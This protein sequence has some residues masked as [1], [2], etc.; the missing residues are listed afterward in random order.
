[1]VALVGPSGAGK[2]TLA[3]LVPRLYDVTAGA[4]RIDGND[5]RDLTQTSLRAAIGVVAQDPH[6]FHESVGANLR[7]ARPDGHAR[8]SWR[9]PAGRPQIHDVIA[10]LP[11]GYDTIVGERG[12]PAVGRREAAPGHRPHAA[13]GPVHRDPRRGHQP[14]RPEN[15]ALVQEALDEALAGPHLDRDRP[16]PVDHPPGRPDLVVDD[17]RI[18]EQGTH[19]ALVE[20]GGLYADLYQTLG[21]GLARRPS[22]LRASREGQIWVW[23]M[24]K[25]LHPPHPR[26]L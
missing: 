12:L 8:P 25:A 4:V 3:S 16:P 14:P 6:L 15:E 26:T 20:A 10:A 19:E 13:E 11:D 24:P 7:Y 5:V 22:G 18:V 1:M 17:G 2:T 21:A 23:V 9:R